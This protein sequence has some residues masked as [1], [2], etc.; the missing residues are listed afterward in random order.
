MPTLEKV[1]G[2]AKLPAFWGATLLQ[3][4]QGRGCSEDSSSNRRR[5]RKRRRK[6][7]RRRRIVPL[8]CGGE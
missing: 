5:R 8:E 4:W 2:A 7:R 3:T 6:R 1:S